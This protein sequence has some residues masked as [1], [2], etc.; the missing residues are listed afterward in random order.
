MFGAPSRA[1]LRLPVVS[2]GSR[3]R[4]SSSRRDARAVRKAAR[5]AADAVFLDLDDAVARRD[6]ATARTNV[7]AALN[8]VDWGTKASACASTGSMQLHV[9][10]K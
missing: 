10:R 2:S 8:D 1:S 7:I 4:S 5:S 6:K 3:A 9:S